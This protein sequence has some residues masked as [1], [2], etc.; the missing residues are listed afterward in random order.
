MATKV[1]W[2]GTSGD[3]TTNANWLDGTAPSG[4]D[5]L[6]FP[7]GAGSLTASLNQ[8]AVTFGTVTIEAGYT[9]TIGSVAS[10]VATYFRFGCTGLTCFG[11]PTAYLDIGSSAISP[12]IYS[13][14]QADTGSFGVYLKGSAIATLTVDRGYV[15]LAAI[16]GET[17]TAT[18]VRLTGSGRLRCG[19]GVTLTN[20][21]C[22]AGFMELFCALTTLTLNGGQCVTFGTG[23]ITTVNVNGGSFFGNST[24]TITTLNGNAGASVFTGNGVGRTVTTANVYP[25]A[26]LV[27][28]SSTLTITNWGGVAKPIRLTATGA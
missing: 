10:G 14:A 18:T 11:Q 1:W 13:S 12:Q 17:S 28:D 5:N 19:S 9:G 16:A 6:V 8:S 20:A 24:G 21:K 7:A 4:G 2:G 23:A 25:G 27:Y 3:F 22:D 15:G 26:S